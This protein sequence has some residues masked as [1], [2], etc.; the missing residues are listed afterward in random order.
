MLRK[1]NNINITL[2]LLFRKI[3]C[4]CQSTRFMAPFC[5]LVNWDTLNND[6][7]A[8][9]LYKNALFMLN[10]RKDRK[11]IYPVRSFYGV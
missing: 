9:D 6:N 8:Y 2:K 4:Y 3:P 10:E 11:R 5:Q 7:M 1:R